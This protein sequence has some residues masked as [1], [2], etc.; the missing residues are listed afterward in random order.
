MTNA[1]IK[2]FIKLRQQLESERIKVSARLKEVDEA[3]G[4]IQLPSLAALP[5][6]E[7][8]R[9]GPKPASKRKVSNEVSLKDSI[10]KVIGKQQMTKEQILEGVIKSGYRFRTSNPAN[11][12]NVILYGKKP[13]FSRKDGKFGV[14]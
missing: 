8:K 2:K 10:L 13:K 6:Q 1:S 14:A 3:L 7:G 11:S 4:T 9:R 5:K 12:L